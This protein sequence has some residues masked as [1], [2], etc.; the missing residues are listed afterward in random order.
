MEA[1]WSGLQQAQQTVVARRFPDDAFAAVG[2][3]YGGH[4]D[5]LLAQPKE[6]APGAAELGKLGEHQVDDFANA[7]VR[8]GRNLQ[9]P[10]G[11]RSR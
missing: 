11:G 8:G 5:A 6:H 1:V 7:L 3:A 2:A 10:R 4:I 9:N